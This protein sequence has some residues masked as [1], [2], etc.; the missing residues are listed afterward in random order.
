MT[1]SQIFL[2]TGLYL[3]ACVAVAFFTRARL[4][5]IAGAT[6]GGAVFGIVA[7][8][9][10]ALCQAQGWWR[11]PRSGASYFQFLLSFCFA[12]FVHA[13]LPDYLEGGTPVRCTWTCCVR[14]RLD[15]YRP[16]TRLHSCRS[17]SELD[18]LLPRYRARGR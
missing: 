4:L 10:V 9:A 8:L 18:D 7:V 2:M 12:V 11:V 13:R 15:S 3:A 17:V 14:R 16:A 6:A 5:R 1:T